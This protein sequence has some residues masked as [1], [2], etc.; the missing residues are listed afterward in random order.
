MSGA[1]GTRQDMHPETPTEPLP[2]AT[3][4][5]GMTV[6]DRDGD[7]AGTVTAVQM[8]GTDV[9]PDV[10]AG[11]AEELMGA[12]YIRIDGTGFLSNDTYSGGDQISK[13]VE[14]DPGVV[15]LRVTRGDL[16]RAT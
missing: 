13:T 1:R 7:E 6:V 12:G 5:V 10:V 15:E 16:H 4:N 14:G 8:P 2:I 9:R 3:V 11:L